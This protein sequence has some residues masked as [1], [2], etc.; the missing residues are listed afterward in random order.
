MLRAS[1]VKG[2]VRVQLFRPRRKPG[3]RPGD[4]EITIDL[5]GTEPKRFA[6]TRVRWTDPTTVVVGLD[7]VSDRSAAEA[8][9]GGWVRVDL[10]RL[11]GA[12]TDEADHLIGALAV[13]A[14]TGQ[15]LGVIDA[16]AD[17]GA[18]PLIVLQAGEDEK[19]VPYV[20]EFVLGLERGASGERVVRLR[21][22]PGLL[23]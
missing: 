4:G 5:E 6:I 16:I 20:A 22:I 18:Q 11:P 15:E 19:L 17:N 21:L 13:D 14:D 23:D 12:I 8:L 1:G 7:G 2:D 9:A 10:E 3:T